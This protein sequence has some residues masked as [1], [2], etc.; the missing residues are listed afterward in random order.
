MTMGD[1]H[2]YWDDY[3]K[4]RVPQLTRELDMAFIDHRLRPEN[5]AVIGGARVIE[6]TPEY[7]LTR[8]VVRRIMYLLLHER[9]RHA[10]TEFKP[11]VLEGDGPGIMRGAAE[12]ARLAQ[13]Q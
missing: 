12:G 9:Q 8:D 13:E 7:K 4:A 1:I 6:G 2:E 10:I 3:C 11:G 5:L